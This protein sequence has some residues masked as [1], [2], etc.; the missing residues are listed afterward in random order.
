MS[1]CSCIYVDYDMVDFYREQP[2]RARKAYCC[3]ECSDQIMPG[4]TYL[5]IRHKSDGFP[6]Q[7]RRMCE[8]CAA[9]VAEFFCDGYGFGSVRAD[10]REHIWDMKGLISEKCLASLPVKARAVVCD[11][12]EE[13]WKGLYEELDLYRIKTS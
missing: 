3:S 7:V 10:L 6:F 2:R 12:I 9:L 4:E 13:C 1:N 11:M 5:D 8:S